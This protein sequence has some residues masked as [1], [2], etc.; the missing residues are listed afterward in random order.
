MI[1]GTSPPCPPRL[2]H[3]LSCMMDLRPYVAA[4][5]PPDAAWLTQQLGGRLASLAAA[6]EDEA[7][8]AAATDGR[9]SREAVAVL[10]RRVCGLQLREELLLTAGAQAVAAAGAPEAASA[11]GG[12]G[13]EGG[14]RLAAAIEL[15]ELYADALPY[16]KG[17]DERERGPADELLPLAAAAL[18][19][20]SGA[21]AGSSPGSSPA[22][23]DDL[24]AAARPRL[25]AVLRA[26]MVLEAGAR[27]RPFSG[28]CRLGLA[29]LY[30]LLGCPAAAAAHFSKTDAK[31]IQMDTLASHHLLPVALALGADK[32]CVA[33]CAECGR[34]CVAVVKSLSD[35]GCAVT[36]C[37]R[38]RSRS[39][40]TRCVCFA[41]ACT[42]LGCSR[43][44][45]RGIG[46]FD[47][48]LMC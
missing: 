1:Y 45:I 9:A 36:T 3:L 32:V 26:I 27:A 25:E 5:S 21:A 28:E 24:A 33:V 11:T 34:S 10:R 8:A 41:R 44:H 20:Q 31:H 17:L 46:N 40:P 29:G 42:P 23:G 30:G 37:C 2:G 12:G 47:N 6:A 14:Q 22:G 15:A 39:A 43:T 18:M 4:L 13:S 48:N 35:I 38:W 19:R 7:A 16:S